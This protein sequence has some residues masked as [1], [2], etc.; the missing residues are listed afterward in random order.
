MVN[1]SQ[2]HKYFAVITSYI[3]AYTVIFILGYSSPTQKQLVQEKVLGYYSLPLFAGIVYLTK[4]FGY[5][6][7][8]FLV[9][10]NWSNN[11]IGVVNCVIGG[12]GWLLVIMAQSSNAIITGV[13]LVGFYSGVTTVVLSSYVAEISL[14]QQ[15][16][17][18]CGGLG[19]NMT[20]GL[21]LVYSIGI[22]LSF[23]WLAVAGLCLVVLFAC[24]M[25]FTPH[26][27]VWFVRQGLHTRAVDTLLYLH[28]DDF[29]ANTEIQN[30]N[31][32]NASAQSSLRASL[33]ALKDLTVVKP[34]LIVSFYGII[35]EFGGHSAMVSL[36]SHILETQQGMNPKVAAIFYPIFL[37]LGAILS[38]CV[39]GKWKLKWQLISSVSLQAISHFSFSIYYLVSEQVLGCNEDYSRI[40]H[41]ISFW[42][43]FNIALYALAFG[44]GFRSILYSL[45]GIM[46]SSHRELSFSITG[47]SLNISNFF[48]ILTFYFL[49]HLIG[50]SLMFLLFTIMHIVTAIYVFVF[51]DV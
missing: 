49:L 42:P 4:L 18:L 32:T 28:G 17:L 39:V 48:V 8:P 38:M 6:I 19:F 51:I 7:S 29:D 2:I 9:Q 1:F 11:L 31:N 10:T 27:P 14:Q 25:F 3:G 5:L 34:I 44:F 15:R 30:I 45:V 35:E 26:S 41:K 22:W 50:G 20:M 23:R 12:V 46:Y 47:V 36:S 33:I 21:L 16:S 40:C 24:L 13:G 43:I 37:I